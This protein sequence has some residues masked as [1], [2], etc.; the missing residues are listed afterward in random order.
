MRAMAKVAL[1]GT[2]LMGAGLAEAMLRRGGDV[3]VYNRTRAKAEPLAKLGA[4]VAPTPAECVRGAERVHVI[5]SDDAAV[6]ALLDAFVDALSSDC[7]V[8]DHS[9]V[10]PAGT[11]AR[12]AR[13]DARG[14]A[15]LHA[16]VFMAPQNCREGGGIMMCAGPASRFERVRGELAKM[17]GD[18]W[19]VGER[20]DSA[21]AYKLFGNALLLIIVGGLADVYA[22][23]A[24]LGIS[25]PDAHALFSR[26]KPAT[27]IDV[28]GKRMA[29]ADFAATFELA[30]ARKDVRLMIEAAGG[31]G[32]TL[33]PALA[34]R[35]DEE[36][37]KGRGADDAGVIAKDAVERARG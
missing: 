13:L 12:F 33:L 26:F 24:A 8:I 14:V 3:T 23:G 30:M 5:V 32:L 28:R 19:F 1:L 10:S 29:N 36:I 20:V 2:G 16:P 9:T 22:I 15:F 34:A 7:V 21:A 35:M 11:V 6:D 18:L 4:R 31:R 27:T 17:T 25:A 37:A